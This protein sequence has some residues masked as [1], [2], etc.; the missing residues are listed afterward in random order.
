MK[1]NKR[2]HCRFRGI[3][4][5]GQWVSC[6]TTWWLHQDLS[7]LWEQKEEQSKWRLWL[8]TAKQTD[9]S[10]DHGMGTFSPWYWDT[11]AGCLPVP[12][13]M[14]RYWVP[15]RQSL[16]CMGKELPSTIL[17]S[18]LNIILSTTLE[19]LLCADVMCPVLTLAKARGDEDILMRCPK[20]VLPDKYR[21]NIK[22]GL[23][24]VSAE[25]GMTQKYSLV[26]LSAACVALMHSAEESGLYPLIFYT[27]FPLL[28]CISSTQG[29]LDHN[30]FLW[31]FPSS[32]FLLEIVE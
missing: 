30:S 28:L 22:M 7:A 11:K 14:C 16:S 18:I 29:Q 1:P 3:T 26:H 32:F 19:R 6:W 10:W 23:I 20:E 25:L 2:N 12:L 24:M 15:I 8:Y 21:L 17:L 9:L 13:L 27:S 31:S 4:L 5:K